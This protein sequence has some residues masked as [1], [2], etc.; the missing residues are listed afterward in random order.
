MQIAFRVDA[1]ATIGTGHVVR[2]L[3]LANTLQ[4]QGVCCTFISRH[5]PTYLQ[6]LIE[7]NGHKSIQIG[8]YCQPEPSDELP[9]AHF[10]GTSQS[11]DAEQTEKILEALRPDWLIIDHYGI[12]RR[13][14]S[15]L[16]PHA[17]KVL[18]IDDLADRDH[19][20]DLL[21]D[22]NLYA[23]M[24]ARYVE[25]IPNS[26][27][28]LLGVQ[29]A[30]L[31]PEFCDAR[32]R[33]KARKGKVQRLFIFFGGMDSANYTLPVLQT[34]ADLKL[35]DCA[36]DVV[37]GAEYPTRNEVQSICKEQ[38]YTCHIQTKDMA[39]LLLKADAAIGAG[40]STSWERCCLGLPSLAFV[41]APN[42]EAL[43]VHADQ[44]GLLRAA[45]VGI[46]D[47][48]ALRREIADFLKA[49][50]ERE[51]MSIACLESIDA[52]GAQR[53]VDQMNLADIQLRAATQDD[54]QLLFEWRNHPSIRAISNNSAPIKW[55]SH[56]YWFNKVRQDSSRPLYIAVQAGIEI[57]VIRFDIDGVQA[58]V[59]LNLA[60]D[61]KGRGLG[62]QLLIQGEQQLVRE[63]P[64]VLKL[65]AKVLEGNK[66]SHRLFRRCGYQFR[67]DTYSKKI[68]V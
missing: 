52:Q 34:L 48:D 9:H 58:E 16:R 38:A 53:I 40:G 6:E 31:R 64:R 68:Q 15:V 8:D 36:V 11:Q 18:V 2:C 46:N 50:V 37:I 61:L 32:E 10:L 66:A 60:P 54:A 12:D 14:E 44:L 43:T 45:H 22:Q 3:T 39:K 30:M 21:V 55:E 26:A 63:H 65:M 17:K 59:S 7:S 20:C 57:G 4:K 33:V 56:Q 62:T 29:Y 42:Q 19:D 67:S 35:N 25:R 13:W 51:C 24:T 23:D 1:S 41:V 5:L 27:K 49:D 28:A 47:D